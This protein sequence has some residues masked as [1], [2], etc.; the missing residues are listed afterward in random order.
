MQ[1]KFIGF[2]TLLLTT[3]L[4]LACSKSS[5]TSTC[6]NVPPEDERNTILHYI[7]TSGLE[8][9]IEDQSGLFYQIIEPG[10]GGSPSLSS[11]V[12]IKYRGYLL[13]G[14]Q[15]DAKSDPTQTGWALGGL[16]VG[17]QIGLPKIK[18]GGKIKLIVPSGYGYGCRGSGSSIPANSIL[19]FDV[20][21][22]DFE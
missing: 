21:L 22:S 7:D 20:E 9:V 19:A 3:G 17:W 18:K 15:F 14:T 4:F 5:S 11:R 8:N 1:K 10:S 6:T 13:D 2:L 16:I 12:Y